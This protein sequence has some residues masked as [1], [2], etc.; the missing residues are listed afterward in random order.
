MVSQ[1]LAVAVLLSGVI[2]TALV[3]GAPEILSA[4]VSVPP[5]MLATA[6]SYVRIRAFGMPASIACSVLQAFFLACK[7][8]WVPLRAT[9]CAAVIN[10]FGDLLLCCVF[11]MG[12][13]GTA[14]ATA[15]MLPPIHRAHSN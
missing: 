8:P 10:L 13:A 9:V 15:G 14:A 3:I 11:G 1:A 6:S 7:E 2:A 12:A 5:D 4:F